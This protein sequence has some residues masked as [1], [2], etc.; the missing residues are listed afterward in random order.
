ML[1]G[2]I[3]NPKKPALFQLSSLFFSIFFLFGNGL[4]Q[5]IFSEAEFFI[6]KYFYNYNFL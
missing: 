2:T 6:T 5:I 3:N 4:F 1:Q